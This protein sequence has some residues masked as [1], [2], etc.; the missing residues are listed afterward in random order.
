MSEWVV[1]S[2]RP[3]AWLSLD[4][5]DNELA[6][7]LAYFVA[8]LQT[9][10]SGVGQGLLTA[11]Q[12]PGAV[13]AEGVLTTLLNEVAESLDSFALVLDDYHVIESQAVDDALSFTLDH[14]APQMHLIIASRTDPS[15][16]LARLR[17]GGHL[18]EIRADDLRFTFD[19]IATF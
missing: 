6:R 5:R 18:T 15:L 11:L 8:A 16:P 7:F 17:A 19:E 9:I 1:H 2:R 3:V 4:E 10:E 13:N 12:V 14:P